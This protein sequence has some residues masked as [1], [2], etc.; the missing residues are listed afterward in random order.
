MM[1]AK[2]SSNFNIPVSKQRFVQIFV[3]NFDNMFILYLVN[4][5]GQKKLVRLM[6]K[7]DCIFSF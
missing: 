6:F 7:T 3:W 1:K 5:L 4:T 2:K